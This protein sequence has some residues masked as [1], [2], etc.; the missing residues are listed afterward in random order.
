[1]EPMILVRHIA[2]FAALTFFEGC[3][4]VGE[5]IYAKCQWEASSPPVLSPAEFGWVQT[6]RP[7]NLSVPAT[8]LGSLL[9]AGEFGRLEVDASE[10]GP[11]EISGRMRF[12]PQFVVM[13]EGMTRHDAKSEIQR[14]KREY[15]F[16]FDRLQNALRIA[17]VR[18]TDG[19]Y[20]VES[21]HYR[22]ERVTP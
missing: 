17:F 21:V 16:T 18:V 13:Q 10:V 1:M 22:C 7:E 20:H 9:S 3:G 12:T 14:G 11:T 2:I 8:Y 5:F 15:Q 6:A 19:V 4:P